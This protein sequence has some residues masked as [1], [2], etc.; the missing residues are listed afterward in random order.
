MNGK[1]RDTSPERWFVTCGGRRKE[2]QNNKKNPIAKIYRFK[3]KYTFKKLVFSFQSL[4]KAP[5]CKAPLQEE[6]STMTKAQC[7]ARAALGV[8]HWAPHCG[9]TQQP[10]ASLAPGLQC[11]GEAPLLPVGLLLGGKCILKVFSDKSPGKRPVGP[12]KAS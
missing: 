11:Q 10:E 6:L 4:K 2:K 9:H 12:V 5:S 8:S 7:L 3:G 1:H